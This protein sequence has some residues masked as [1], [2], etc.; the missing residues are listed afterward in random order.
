M[1]RATIAI[2]S[3]A[4]LLSL[5]GTGA[6]AILPDITNWGGSFLLSLIR[7][8]VNG[9]VTAEEI[10]GN[11]LTGVVFKDLTVSGP[12]GKVFLTVDRLEVRLS[13]ASI[14]TFRLDLGTLALDN[15]RVYLFREP[16]GQWN[17]SRL[18]KEE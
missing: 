10:S 18:M 15:P 12:D 2:V 3:L 1:R 14:P 8:K 4:L 9:Q 16:S 17:F 6:G 5:G 11:P 7:S 13:L